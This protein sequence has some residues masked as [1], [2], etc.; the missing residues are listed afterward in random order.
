MSN[1]IESWKTKKL[2]NLAIPLS[3]LY[4]DEDAYW[5]PDK[6]EIEGI[7]DNEI[8]V[9]IHVC[10]DGDITGRIRLD[11]TIF[12]DS[13][14]LRGESSGHMF[15]YTVEPALHKSTG[16][17]EAVLI[18]ESSDITRL[19]VHDGQVTQENIEL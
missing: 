18:W 9:S 15:F 6:P 10:E 16:I 4:G 8:R 17:L 13:I 2:E 1:N 7:E 14:K 12:V 5:N 11:N 3:A 19:I